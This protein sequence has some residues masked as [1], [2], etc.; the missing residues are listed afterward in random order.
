M[1]APKKNNNDMYIHTTPDVY[2]DLQRVNSYNQW[3]RFE[4]SIQQKA[5]LAMRQG[6]TQR[7]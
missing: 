5:L 7:G 1:C 4:V 6:V 2:K 3:N